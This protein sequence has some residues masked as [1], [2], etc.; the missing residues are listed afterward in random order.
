MLLGLLGFLVMFA[1]E[2][3]TDPG[4]E[5]D[6]DDGELQSGPPT[7]D[8]LVFS[9]RS[10]VTDWD[11][12]RMYSNGNGQ[13]PITRTPDVDEID[14]SLSPDGTMI[15]YAAADDIFVMNVDGSGVRNLTGGMT[16]D[17]EEQHPTWL[18]DGTQIAFAGR[19]NR[20]YDL[21]TVPVGGS[22]Q[23]APLITGGGDQLQPNIS[24][25]G[26]R[27]AYLNDGRI[28]ITTLADGSTE[29][30]PTCPADDDDL[31]IEGWPRWSHDGMK[32]AWTR[33]FQ[34]FEN[35]KTKE[36]LSAVV[37]KTIGG[38]VD[39]DNELV[40]LV[41]LSSAWSPDDSHLAFIDF[42]QNIVVL[43]VPGTTGGQ[44][45]ELVSCDCRFHNG[46]SWGDARPLVSIKDGSAKEGNSGTRQMR[47]IVELSSASQDPVRV[48]YQ[49]QA[50]TGGA[51]QGSDF[52][53][54]TGFV[55]IGPGQT[56][57]YAT[58]DILGDT[59]LE[60]N[61][62]LN[63]VASL[64][65]DATARLGRSRAYGT[66]LDDDKPTPTPRPSPTPSTSSPSPSP[67]V[68]S[69]SPGRIVFVSEAG[70][71]TQLFTMLGDGS[72]VQHISTNQASSNLDDPSWSSDGSKIIHT[73]SDGAQTE[74]IERASGVAGAFTVPVPQSSQDVEPAYRG[75]SSTDFW[76]A[77]NEHGD[78]DLF[79]GPGRNHM[80]TST[81]DERDVSFGTD[82]VK[83]VYEANYDGPDFDIFLQALAASGA[84][85]SGSP[86]NL[87][88]EVAGPAA[89]DIDPDLSADGT[90]VVFSSDRTG[91]GDIYVVDVATRTA[92]RLTTDPAAET[93]PTFS[94]DG[95]QIAFVRVVGGDTE[96][97]RMNAT[98]GATAVNISN[99][100]GGPDTSPDWGPASTSSSRPAGSSEIAIALP[101]LMAAGV[102]VKKVRERRK[103]RYLAE[104]D[105]RIF[106]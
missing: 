38:G 59:T 53:A 43:P 102:T 1:G 47:F 76:W 34:K 45:R 51:T 24:P 66:I 28:A 39:T 63:V 67:S 72:G 81:A 69:L 19:R 16:F 64:P 87:T 91:G 2:C 103:E 42:T 46:L 27:V 52:T 11:V 100:P 48:D 37:F 95:N 4:A 71:F 90:K 10:N 36:N 62:R 60:P 105:R 9:R 56:Q 8:V 31:C 77:S 86:E 73:A 13:R 68:P 14:P 6:R 98:A 40:G 20:N 21:Y 61:E 85:L 3:P 92:T 23:A 54:T 5:L 65:V 97:F 32:V 70:G 84:N 49:T 44:R 50:I 30:L 12:W 83:M 55:T 104:E 82:P 89:N 33:V 93:K 15:A 22:A 41:P 99:N 88:Q 58:V 96:I 35:G 106:S 101:F 29:T 57:E 75:G 17:A 18:P 25:E 7:S 26:T 80:T 79:R 78:F 94:P 74:I